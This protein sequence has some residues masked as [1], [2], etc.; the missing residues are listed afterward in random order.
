MDDRQANLAEH[1]AWLKGIIHGIELFNTFVATCP[2]LTV[3]LEDVSKPYKE[4]LIK[5]ESNPDFVSEPD[6]DD[7]ENSSNAT[8]NEPESTTQEEE[9]DDDE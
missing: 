2:G 7:D 3:N 5:L 4:K 1:T 6:A 8:F 9:D